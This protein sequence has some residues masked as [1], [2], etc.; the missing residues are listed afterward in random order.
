MLAL[1]GATGHGKRWE[2]LAT[3]HLPDVRFIAPDLRGHGRS[4][5]L[6][7]WDF[8][9]IAADAAELLAA[10]TDEPALVVGHSLGGT[11]A[12]YL[13]AKYPELVRGLVLLD[14][15]AALDPELAYRYAES[16][17]ASPD[18]TD[19]DEAR[20]DKRST[21]WGEVEPRL[22]EAELAEHLIPTEG[23]RVG[24]RI[25]QLAITSYLG[26]LARPYVLPP[27]GLPTVLVQAMKT[28]PPFVT[29]EFRAALTE[30]LGEHL[31]AQDW[32]CGHMVAQA[33]PAETAA[34]IRTML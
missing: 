22:L 23:G 17:L 18:Y 8:E 20:N 31:T 21:A 29:P 26:Q 30:H 34:V 25:S 11:G 6:P 10:E 24:W 32:D 28:E 4:S 2:A 7:P 9:T 13:A 12:V 16:N 5:Y 33:R 1:H 14:P 3:E 15:A 19:I 27:A